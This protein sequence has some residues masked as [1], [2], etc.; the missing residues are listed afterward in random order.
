MITGYKRGAGTKRY[1]NDRPPSKN[2]N[3]RGV[4]VNQR[5]E[6]SVYTT[7]QPDLIMLFPYSFRFVLT[8]HKYQCYRL[9]YTHYPSTFIQTTTRSHKLYKREP[10]INRHTHKHPPSKKSTID[11]WAS[12]S[13]LKEAL[14]QSCDHATAIILSIVL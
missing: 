2:K 1:R 7:M 8:A 4:R 11:G 9:S 5:M 13:S 10:T 14:T 3:N 12:A 6:H